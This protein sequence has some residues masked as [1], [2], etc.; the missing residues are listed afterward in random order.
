MSDIE[1]DLKATADSLAAD[2]RRLRDIEQEK[3][4]LDARDPRMLAL[5]VEAE[6]I[7]RGM[8]PKTVAE[9]ELTEEAANE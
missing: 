9:R 1:S 3:S 8:V 2:A 6:R 4:R 7:T 5:A